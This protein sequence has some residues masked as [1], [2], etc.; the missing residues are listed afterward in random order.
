[1]P[2]FIAYGNTCFQERW[3]KIVFP[4]YVYSLVRIFELQAKNCYEL[5]S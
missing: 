3:M 5:V 2:I 1:L 4:S